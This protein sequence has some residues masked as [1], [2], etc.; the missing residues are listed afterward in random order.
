MTNSK[1]I[2]VQGSP[3][4]HDR[5]RRTVTNILLLGNASIFGYLLL[6]L[7]NPH[8]AETCDETPEMIDRGLTDAESSFAKQVLG[9][10]FKTQDI[11]LHFCQNASPPS[12]AK[13][14]NMLSA[15]YFFEGK[16]HSKDFTRAPDIE[17]S[18]FLHEMTH[19][20]QTQNYGFVKDFFR[21]AEK[22]GYDYSVHYGD[23]FDDFGSEQQAAMIEDYYMHF[24]AK[25]GMSTYRPYIQNP[26]NLHA[27]KSI[28][29]SHFPHIKPS[30]DINPATRQQHKA[31]PPSS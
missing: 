8:M 21:M 22:R 11:R 30:G 9:S 31:L 28:V 4:A 1:K 14:R 29:E 26:E 27:L 6:V 24:L 19:L 7:N 12:L 15:V 18:I 20:W 10:D 23:A 5:L 25:D 3:Q 13:T 17:K 2:Q 16:N